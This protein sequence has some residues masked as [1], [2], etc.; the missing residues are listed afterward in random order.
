VLKEFKEFALKGNAVDLAIGLVIGVAFGAIV[1]SLV[2]D[3]IMPLVGLLLGGADFS[4]LF[5]VL[6]EGTK[7]A[8]PYTS[9]AAAQA[10][11][12]NTLNWGRFV[13]YIISFLIIAFSIFM[14]VKGMNRFRR[15]EEATT[16]ACPFCATDIPIA[17]SKCPACTSELPA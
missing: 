12:A 14:V 3:L 5:V 7:A 11:G 9:L 6:K 4:N 13:N 17:A 2:N 1:T 15:A 16:K 8:G 10:A